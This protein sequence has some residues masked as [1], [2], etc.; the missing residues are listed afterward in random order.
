MQRLVIERG[1]GRVEEFPLDSDVVSV[2]V[3]RGQVR[4]SDDREQRDLLLVR[5][6]VGYV[7]CGS[8]S[9]I[10]S[11]DGRFGVQRRLADGD[12]IRI[13]PR[14]LIYRDEAAPVLPPGARAT[15]FDWFRAVLCSLCL[16]FLLL[17]ILFPAMRGGAGDS[18]DGAG[19]QLADEGFGDGSGGGNGNG[20]GPGHGFGDE[21]DG[22][23]GGGGD[24]GEGSGT[25]GAGDA[26]AEPETEAAEMA[27][28]SPAEGAA[29]EAPRAETEVEVEANV[30]LP[31]PSTDMRI[32][33]I[34]PSSVPRPATTTTTASGSDGTFGGGGQRLGTGDVQI[35]LI[36]DTAPDVDLHVTDPNGEE[37][38]FQHKFSRSGGE[39][40]VDDTTFDGPENVYWPTGGAPRGRYRVEVV[41]FG[42]NTANWR[43]RTR[44]DGEEKTYSGRLTHLGQRQTVVSFIR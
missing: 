32:S 37:I 35:T 7:F 15:G 13:G 41:L 43:V 23:G 26:P 10:A 22:G 25:A 27:E 1:E 24:Q 31:Q 5:D 16:L 36:W 39:L 40:D 38:W 8:A 20:E 21:G 12:R 44:I 29:E 4:V 33:A 17:L 28:A 30:E 3:A 11:L 6:G 18:G 19:T 42:G 9:G 14:E 34:T 2:G